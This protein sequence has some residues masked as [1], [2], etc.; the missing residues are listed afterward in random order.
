MIWKNKVLHVLY[1]IVDPANTGRRVLARAVELETS[2]LM[3]E[4]EAAAAFS[5]VFSIIK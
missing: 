2:S 1:T 4:K 5:R 3:A